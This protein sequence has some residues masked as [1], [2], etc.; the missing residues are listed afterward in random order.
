MCKGSTP[1]SVNSVDNN[2]VMSHS[3]ARTSHSRD[4]G[5]GRCANDRQKLF[6]FCSKSIFQ[7]CGGNLKAEASVHS[8]FTCSNGRPIRRMDTKDITV[9][10]ARKQT[11]IGRRFIVRNQ[12]LS[13]HSCSSKETAASHRRPSTQ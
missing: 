12:G 2:W 4:S 1:T 6:K 13:V 9:L 5:D 8:P 11:K 7:N 3:K 10:H